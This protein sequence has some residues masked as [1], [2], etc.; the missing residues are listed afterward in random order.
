MFHPPPH[1]G[2]L[3][4]W[5]K[6]LGDFREA[7]RG[8]REVGEF[9][10]VGNHGSKV[11]PDTSSCSWG[12]GKG[13]ERR[14]NAATF[15]LHQRMQMFLNSWAGGNPGKWDSYQPNLTPNPLST[16]IQEVYAQAANEKTLEASENYREEKGGQKSVRQC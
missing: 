7:E 15:L 11:W 12:Q 5:R 6:T 2:G 4:G 13:E 3:T 10:P 1:P 8:R 14:E 9:H 16:H